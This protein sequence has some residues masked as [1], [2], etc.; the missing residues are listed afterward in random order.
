MRLLTT[1]G[2]GARAAGTSIKEGVKTGA[3]ETFRASLMANLMSDGNKTISER[4]GGALG[5][6]L[7]EATFGQMGALGKALTA[8]GDK[9]KEGKSPT[10]GGGVAGRGIG[11]QNVKTDDVIV[12]INQ[13]ARQV[14]G[15][16]NTLN[17]TQRMGFNAQTN[18]IQ[19]QAQSIENLSGYGEDTVIALREIYELLN[20][21]G[22]SSGSRGGAGGGSSLPSYQGGSTPQAANDNGNSSGVIGDTLLGALAGGVLGAGGALLAG[23]RKLLGKAGDATAKAGEKIL[24]KAGE[25]ALVKSALKKLPGIGIIAGLAFGVD[26]LM[27]GDLL[28]AGGEVL[29]G[30]LGTV[31]GLGTAASVAVDA[32]LAARDFGAFGEAGSADAAPVGAES[33]TGN[34]SEGTELTK[35]ESLNVIHAFQ[36]QYGRFGSRDEILQFAQ[37]MYPGRKF[38]K[39]I[40]TIDKLEKSS[41]P[42]SS[43]TSNVQLASNEILPGMLGSGEYL[44]QRQQQLDASRQG[45][46]I[47]TLSGTFGPDTSEGSLRQQEQLLEAAAKKENMPDKIE[48][49]ARELVYK[50]DNVTF[51][52]D[53]LKFIYK[54]KEEGAAESFTPPPTNDTYNNQTSGPNQGLGGGGN[55]AASPVAAPMA[56]PGGGAANWGAVGGTESRDGSGVMPQQGGATAGGKQAGTSAS[57]AQ[58][59]IIREA[60]KLGIDPTDLATVISYETGGSFNPNKMGGKGGNYM[61]LIQFGPNERKKYG[62][63]PNMTFDQ[64]MVAVGRYLQDRGLKKWLDENQNASTMDKRT[65]LYSTINAGSPGRKYWGRSDRPGANVMSH[66]AEM[67]R[68]GK[69]GQTHRGNAEAFMSGAFDETGSTASQTDASPVSQSSPAPALSGGSDTGSAPSPTPQ[70]S[71]PPTLSGGAEA[72]GGEQGGQ[73]AGASGGGKAKV[74]EAYGGHRPGRPEQRIINL[75]QQAASKAGMSSVVLTSGKGNWISPSGRAKGQKTTMHS[76]GL[77]VDV[78]ASSFKTPEQRH[79]FIAAAK[80]GGAGGIGVYKDKSVHVDFGKNRSW[81]WGD[82]DQA[83]FQKALSG[84]GGSSGSSAPDASP[85]SSSGGGGESSNM[86]SGATMADSGGSMGGGLSFGGATGNPLA[87]MLGGGGSP[88]GMIG[89]LLGGVVGQL[90]NATSLFSASGA[91]AG[92]STTMN[93]ASAGPLPDRSRREG[94]SARN[95]SPGMDD[96]LANLIK[97]AFG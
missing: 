75:A 10:S 27:D 47:P 20:R 8:G 44:S 89:N 32:G 73:Q 65:A 11:Y 70:A 94:P 95:P 30:V 83:G 41:G 21:Q 19:A 59:A 57:E 49:Q 22:Y 90:S 55:E 79:A 54:T 97:H 64:Q 14:V 52:V 80:A 91:S 13:S 82:P 25:K 71:S 31:P 63:R 7:R 86:G 5:D 29:S 36:Q 38:S 37:S 24:G 35:E 45:S 67:F 61:G 62:I 40:S 74:I 77:A 48:I 51:D 42:Q 60:N 78:G 17:A 93:L 9:S 16:L 2:K 18:Q 15:A 3:K 84:G 68:E 28:G 46:D 87:S 39:L 96:T 69:K 85:V 92:S 4:I 88:F 26:R 76:T 72:A 43:L 50:A 12:A 34:S 53:T 23:G 58:K 81:N 56:T 1:L 66:T 33:A 6:S